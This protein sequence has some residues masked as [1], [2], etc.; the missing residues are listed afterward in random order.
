VPVSPSWPLAGGALR[1]QSYPPAVGEWSLTPIR[2]GVWASAHTPAA[3]AVVRELP[4]EPGRLGVVVD[5]RRP[6]AGTDRLIDGLFPALAVPGGEVRLVLSS[7][8]DRYGRAVADRFGLDV[9]AAEDQVEITP[10][11]HGLVRPDA[12]LSGPG[13]AS[14][15]G[16]QTGLG[17]PVPPGAL[18]Q[19]RRCLPDG[20]SQPAGVL[21]PSP[22]WETALSASLARDLAWPAAMC[23][24]PAGLALGRPGAFGRAEYA[25]WPDPERLTIVVSRASRPGMMLDGL[26]RLLPSLPL[27]DSDGIRLYWPRAAAGGIGQAVQQ[28]ARQCGV[29]LIAPAA[30]LGDSGEFGAVSHGP[31]GAA[32]WLRFTRE[33]FTRVLGSLYPVPRWER[34]L[35]NAD[36]DGVAGDLAL[37]HVSAGICVHRPVP[38]EDGLVVTARSLLPDPQRMTVIMSD[39][40]P[41]DEAARLLPAM[42]RRLPGIRDVRLVMAR[43]AAGGEGSLAQ[44]LADASGCEVVAPAGE[45]TATP[46]GRL[47]ALDVSG[48]Q[49]AGWVRFRPRG[50]AADAPST[51]WPRPADE[52]VRLEAPPRPEATPGPGTLG[53]PRATLHYEEVRAPAAAAPAAMPAPIRVAAP[54]VTPAAGPP[55]ERAAEPIA[56]PPARR[57]AEPPAEPA[58]EV[59]L[60]PEPPPAPPAPQK[61]PLPPDAPVPDAMP[62]A[63]NVLARAHRSSEEERLAYRESAARY[64]VHTVTVRRMLTQ[65]PGLRAAGSDDALI[66][67][68]AAVLDFLEVD[69]AV[70]QESLRRPE[71]ALRPW[72][73]CVVSGLR[74]LPSFTGPVFASATLDGHTPGRYATGQ[75]LVEPAFVFATSAP[76]VILDGD[77]E[78]VIWSGTAKRVAALAPDASRD[79]VVYPAG[80]AFRVLSAEAATEGPGR[81]RIFLREAAS[82]E[83]EGIGPGQPGER[84]S[85][86]LERLTA[87]TALRDG[88]ADSDRIASRRAGR[89]GAPLGVDRHGTPFRP[90]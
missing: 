56:E 74:R 71:T 15:P 65:R 11:G 45:W 44:S 10:Y 88:L 86:L 19:W 33:G 5:A 59:R 40:L 13:A 72:A 9:I 24:V 84:D 3:P 25:V 66:T 42:L 43:A 26:A 57:P 83:P 76:Q 64:Q 63:L 35:A 89:P 62:A 61:E 48:P 6:D 58:A 12:W 32:P 29:D 38:A 77:V 18:A 79:E 50:Q 8:A 51:E 75:L 73:A 68:F 28:I 30:D 22:A 81:A 49:S 36:L 17:G 37:E 34:V 60:S 67:D 78:Y 1:P 52:G 16:G 69:P 23:R 46:D 70:L 80:T 87:A 39:G 2:A 7:S 47:Q 14:D 85:G 27:T 90:R 54:V 4:E 31:L 55:V 21:Y 82:S 53:R 41:P 20:E